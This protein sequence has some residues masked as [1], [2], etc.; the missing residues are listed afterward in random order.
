D[1]RP[2]PL[3]PEGALVVLEIDLEP[4]RGRR[5][6]GGA[7]GRPLQPAFSDVLQ[8]A[9]HAAYFSAAERFNARPSPGA[10]RSGRSMPPSGRGTPS[11]SID[12]TR[13]WSWKYSRCRS[14]RTAQN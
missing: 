8:Q 2:H 14:R 11:K 10:E 6:R 12:S 5:E 4:E 7:R 3:V 1:R 9:P 13:T